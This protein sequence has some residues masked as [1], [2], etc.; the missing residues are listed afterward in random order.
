MMTTAQQREQRTGMERHQGEL[1]DALIGEQVTHIL[2]EPGNLLKVQ[3][4]RLWETRYRVNV[5]VGADAA[6]ARIANSY[7]LVTDGNGNVV[8]STPKI[9]RQY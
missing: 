4:R 2:G 1:L 6:T 9:K 5:V 8:S 7:F 3:V